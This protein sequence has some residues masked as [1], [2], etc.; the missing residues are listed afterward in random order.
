MHEDSF[1]TIRNTVFLSEM[2]KNEQFL[3]CGNSKNTLKYS[4]SLENPY[5][6]C[7]N[8]K[9]DGFIEFL[10]KFHINMESFGHIC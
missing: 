2:G 6:K 3:I 5:N 10:V 4:F 8:P 9:I 7:F 1:K